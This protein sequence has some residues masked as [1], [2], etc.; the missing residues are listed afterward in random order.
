[1]KQ[2]PVSRRDFVKT[3]TLVG[4]TVTA[5]HILPPKEA[6]AAMPIQVGLIGCG[7]RGRGDTGRF[8]QRN[9]GVGL[10]SLADV[11]EDRLEDARRY[12]QEELGAEVPRGQCFSG[13][14]AH[15]KMLETDVDIVILTTPPVFR[16][17]MVEAAV[18]AGKHVFLE[19][20][21]A[22]D[23][24]GVRRIIAAGDEAAKRGLSIVAGT[25]RRYQNDYIETI[26]RIHDGAIGEIVSA[27][28]Y[29]LGTPP[30]AYIERGPG[31]SDMEYQI[32][33]WMHFLWLSGDHIVEQHVH[34]IDVVNWAMGT[35]PVRA[36]GFG[37]RAW[38]QQGNIWDHHAIEFEY[39]NGACMTSMCRQ[40]PCPYGRTDE[41]VVGTK[42]SS[43]CSNW[44]GG[45][46][47]EWKFEDSVKDGSVEEA[48]RMVESVRNREPINDARNVAESTMTAIM[49]RMAGYSGKL[50]TWDEAFNSDEKLGPDKYEFGP[51][52]LR[53][54]A[55]PGGAPFD[56]DTGWRPDVRKPAEK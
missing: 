19:K 39:E 32:R 8:I 55:V 7:R 30:R 42:G 14:D 3:G 37:G 45:R 5:F 25:Q 33:N 10:A 52:E 31:C 49:G 41:S 13:W 56:P 22:V 53:P 18:K 40:I 34:N 6:R 12:F 2:K 29:W 43:N 9:E 51:V 47:P 44:I 20:P 26:R 4:A 16:P 28:A 48:V 36:F 38:Q 15:K 17:M 1:M 27:R 54:L 21:A 24:S 50:I 11:M 35:H 46:A 23:A